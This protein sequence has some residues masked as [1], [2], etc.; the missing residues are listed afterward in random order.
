MNIRKQSGLIA[1]IGIAA[2]L[3]LGFF[4]SIATVPAGYVGVVTQF[5]AT[6]GRV[7][8]PGF[9]IKISFIQSAVK[10]SV[11]TQLY[12]AG[13]LTAASK[14]L[15]NV[16]TTIAI[17]YKLDPSKAVEIYKTVGTDY[18]GIIA[19]P[20]IQETVKEITAKYNAEECITKRADVKDQITSAL[21]GRLQSRGIIVETVNI[22]D[23]KFSDEF[24]AAIEAK[25]VAQQQIETAQNTLERMKVEAEQAVVQAQGK[26]DA[27]VVSAQGTAEANQIISQSLT[28]EMLQYILFNNPDVTIILVPDGNGG[29]I[30]NTAK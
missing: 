27:A 6:T 2:I 8:N 17:N 25:V 11:K 20:A 3:L 23:F 28:P 19:H 7:L 26:A 14:D 13:N 4:T 1:F 10:I 18:M 22:T 24:T 30:I 5:G 12:Q 15:Q 16:F 21:I 29:Y 9:N